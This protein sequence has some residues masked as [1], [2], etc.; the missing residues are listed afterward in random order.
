MEPGLGPLEL[1]VSAE[2]EADALAVLAD[3]GLRESELP[4]EPTPE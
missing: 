2:D 4:A 1:Q 3:P